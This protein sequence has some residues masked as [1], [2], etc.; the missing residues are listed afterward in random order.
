MPA[1]KIIRMRNYYGLSCWLHGPYRAPWCD[2]EGYWHTECRQCLDL[3][4]AMRRMRTGE[5][6]GDES[7]DGEV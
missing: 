3:A 6:S 7:R 1:V 5:E 2:D 4:E